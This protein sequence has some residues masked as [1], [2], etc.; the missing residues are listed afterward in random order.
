MDVFLEKNCPNLI[1]RIS[2]SGYTFDDIIEDP[3]YCIFGSPY[4]LEDVENFAKQNDK[5]IETVIK[6]VEDYDIDV[7]KEFDLSS[8]CKKLI[9]AIRYLTTEL[10]VS[11]HVIG[12]NLTKN[13]YE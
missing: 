13:D 6:F 5:E 3:L 11:T 1:Y 8:T 7:I 12:D 9:F 10:A 2:N 4:S